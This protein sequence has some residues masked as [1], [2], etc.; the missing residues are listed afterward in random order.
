MCLPF[1]P[2]A[3]LGRADLKYMPTERGT[4]LLIS[5]W[6]GVARH[7]NYLGDAIMGLAWCLPCGTETTPFLSLAP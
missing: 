3:H 2:V 7:I 6:W 1:S 4:R 5:G